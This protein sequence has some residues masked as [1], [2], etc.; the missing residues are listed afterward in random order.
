MSLKKCALSTCQQR[1]LQ[2]LCEYMGKDFYDAEVAR[3]IPNVS[4]AS[5]NNA[6]RKLAES[7]ITTRYF[8]GNLALNRVEP[9]SAFIKT[10]RELTYVCELHDFIKEAK[11][12]LSYAA[13]FGNHINLPFESDPIADLFFVS[14]KPERVERIFQKHKYSQFLTALPH[15]EEQFT[16]FRSN[17]PSI[18][19]EVQ[20]GLCLFTTGTL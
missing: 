19:K 11:Q 14:S 7:G 16:S 10:Y 8:I 6:L 5:A 20:S 17:S 2:F 15:T 4:R 13:I 1:V 3:L 12:W 9:T 18:W